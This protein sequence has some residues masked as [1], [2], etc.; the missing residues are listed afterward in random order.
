LSGPACSIHF[1]SLVNF[2]IAFAISTY[3]VVK[4]SAS[5]R[6]LRDFDL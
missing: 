1:V 6:E 2:R 3:S 5:G 4:R